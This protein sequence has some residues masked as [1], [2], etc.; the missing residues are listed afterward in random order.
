VKNK[1]AVGDI[2]E[3]FDTNGHN[4][5][6]IIHVARSQPSSTHFTLKRYATT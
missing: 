6:D 4:Q 1:P 5:V 2:L 3:H